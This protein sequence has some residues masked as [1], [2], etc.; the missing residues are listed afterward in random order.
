MHSIT[1]CRFVILLNLIANYSRTDNQVGTHSRDEPMKDAM[2][3]RIPVEREDIVILGCD[4][5][6]DNLVSSPFPLPE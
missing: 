1:P 6:I 5:L 2:S 4:G 3:I